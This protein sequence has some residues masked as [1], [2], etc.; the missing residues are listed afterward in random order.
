[1]TCAR[2]LVTELS[3]IFP[4]PQS[5][6]NSSIN[7]PKTKIFSKKLTRSKGFS[8][9]PN[10]NKKTVQTL[11]STKR[12]ATLGEAAF[13]SSLVM[14]EWPST[15][16]FMATTVDALFSWEFQGIRKKRESI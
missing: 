9:R 10:S 3:F 1:M 7:G 4:T 12:F 2:S 8:K 5:L 14:E 13:I 16:S 6:R 11:K 15:A